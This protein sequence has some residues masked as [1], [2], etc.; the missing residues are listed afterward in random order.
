[1]L[2]QPPR[3]TK[4]KCDKVRAAVRKHVVKNFDSIVMSRGELATIRSS[5]TA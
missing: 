4:Y 1:M 2:C 5:A 3:S